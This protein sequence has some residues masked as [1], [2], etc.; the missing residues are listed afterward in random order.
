M[1]KRGKHVFIVIAA[2]LYRL[3]NGASISKNTPQRFLI[4]QPTN[5]LGDM[6]CTTPL[7]KAIKTHYPAS[8]ITVV[9]SSRNK[10]LVGVH[11][12]IDEYFEFPDS[13]L[14]LLL[15]IR[16][17]NY[18][19]GVSIHM[20]TTMVGALILGGVRS[21]STFAFSQEFTRSQPRLYGL[22]SK[23]VRTVAY[24]P[25]KY[26]PQQYLRL[27]EPF[28][29]SSNDTNK[30]VVFS[31]ESETDILKKFELYFDKNKPIA[32]IAPGAGTKVKQWPAERFGSVANYLAQTYGFNLVI[33]GGPMDIGEAQKMKEVLHE[34]VRYIDCV[35]QSLDELK[36]TLSKVSIII[37][38]DS[39]PI[40][41]AESFGAA[42][43]VIVGPTDESEHPLQD[44]THRVVK[45][46]NRGEALL[47]SYLSSEDTIDTTV[48]RIQIE[49][50]NTD[51]VCRELDDLISKI[52]N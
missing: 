23:L 37:G 40:Y 42:T 1:I 43:L 41:I 19:G 35:G 32:A 29:I 3:F 52:K 48:A 15:H 36:A 28:G 10:G 21:I 13:F 11:P 33:I 16:R 30:C 49:S 7:F 9:G 17:G 31:R 38:N 51:D 14:K 12:Y 34:N 44:V 25:G 39:A 24:A 27:L 45:A 2:Y 4:L 50:I 47:R 20:D 18:D 5:N 26:M 22:I 46:S 6:V 8:H